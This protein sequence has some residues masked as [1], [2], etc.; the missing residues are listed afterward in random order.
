M[1]RDVEE[2]AITKC[3]E[4]GSLEPLIA[5]KIT[6]EHFIDLEMREVFSVLLDQQTRF[7]ALPSVEVLQSHI[8][9]EPVDCEDVLEALMDLM[10]ETLVY[11]D[12]AQF[13]RKLQV[14]IAQNPDTRRV[15]FRAKDDLSKLV[16]KH[17][18]TS[19]DLDAIASSDSIM[20][21]Y[22]KKKLAV[23]SNDGIIG[24]PWMWD[25]MNEQTGGINKEDEFIVVYGEAKS[26]K[27][28][29]TLATLVH[30]HKTT[31]E[32]P[33]FVT[34]EMSQEEV[35]DRAFC[36]FSGLDWARLSKG[37]LLPEE[38]MTFKLKLEEFKDCPPF[39]IVKVNS[40]GMDAVSEYQSKI[41]EHNARLAAFDGV[42]FLSQTGNWQEIMQVTR[43]M[44]QISLTLKIPMFAVT[45]GN[46]EGRAMY[47]KSFQQDATQMLCVSCPP[48]NRAQREVLISSPFVRNAMP[49]PFTIHMRLGGDLSQKRVFYS[50]DAADGTDGDDG[51]IL[52]DGQ[53]NDEGNITA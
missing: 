48:E 12:M 18:D 26:Y 1:S 17:A 10:R 7:G 46:A 51:G 32:V 29:V 53:T 24:H 25:Y 36:L 6:K 38:E 30:V 13:Q 44:R 34:K 39:H 49:D 4:L 28:W 45:Q 15:L 20:V 33:L 9:F 11:N 14:E 3:L 8:A 23:E 50:G 21:R 37:R 22:E 42:Y 47:S 2:R 40:T 5:G 52:P 27:T 41:E 43:A 31:G 35:Q 16:L 19:D